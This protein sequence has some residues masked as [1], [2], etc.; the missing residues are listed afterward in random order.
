MDSFSAQKG[1]A[2]QTIDC[3]A[4]G[5]SNVSKEGVRAQKG[6]GSFG[7]VVMSGSIGISP[8]VSKRT[9]M[10]LLDEAIEHG[11]Q[12]SAREHESTMANIT[13]REPRFASQLA[14]KNK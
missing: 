11:A 1:S 10:I 8:P 12:R 14:A 4:F 7:L 13:D 2:F 6:T 3:T 5:A 9:S